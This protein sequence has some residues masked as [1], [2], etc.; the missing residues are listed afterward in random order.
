MGVLQ[1]F[2]LPLAHHSG[3]QI[4]VGTN[5]MNSLSPWM[6]ARMTLVLNSA[7]YFFLWHDSDLLFDLIMPQIRA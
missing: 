1:E 3:V 2:L 6:I 7:V 4:K 5:G